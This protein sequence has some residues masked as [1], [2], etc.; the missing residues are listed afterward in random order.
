MKLSTKG[1]YGVA[2]MYDLALHYGQ[3]PISLKNV[4]KRQ[5][6]SEHYLE[7]LMGILR[8]AGYVKSIR[9]AQGGYTLTKDPAEIT[10][11]D[12]IRIME[13]P[14]APVD[15]LLTDNNTCKRA[16]ICVTRGVWAKVRDSISQVLDSISLADLCREEKDK[17]DDSHETD[18]F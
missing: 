16:D 8:K 5:G 6:I 9:G 1:R 13:G 4:A 14:I 12:I 3:G 17:G 2:A 7:Q 15:C 11:G 10:V 18:L